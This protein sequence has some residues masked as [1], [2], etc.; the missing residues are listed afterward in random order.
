M[1][2]ESYGRL[3]SSVLMNKI[4]QDLPLIVSREI[5]GGDWELDL[6]LKVLHQ[7]LEARERAAGSQNTYNPTTNTP[8]RTND[9]P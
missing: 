2:S 3:L 6:F 5:K 9:Q 1:S 4:P 8:Q 7:E